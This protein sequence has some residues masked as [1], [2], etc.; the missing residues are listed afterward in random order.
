[1]AA[2]KDR[3][4]LQWP[5]YVLIALSVLTKGPLSLVLCGLTFGAA[6]L[7]S[8]DLRRRLLALHVIGGLVV[9]LVIAVPWFVYMWLRFREA[10]VAGFRDASLEARLVAVPNR[11]AAFAWLRDT[12]R[13]GDAVI[14]END[15]PDLYERSAGLFWRTS[16]PEAKAS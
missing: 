4:H 14:L 6:V 2:L 15:L 8:A 1:M 10:F 13:D 16:R 9:V 5:G 12:L 3:P 11:T 7:V